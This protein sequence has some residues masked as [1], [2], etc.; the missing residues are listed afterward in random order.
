MTVNHPTVFVRRECYERFGLFD[1]DYKCA[2][3][4]DL[5]LRLFMNGCRFVHIPAVLANMRWGGLSD[6]Q[7][8]LGCRETLL[9]KNKYLPA[10][11]RLNS[12]YY[13]KHIMAIRAPKI[14]QRLGFGFALRVY[15]T[16]FAPFRKRYK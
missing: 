6:S 8:K 12:L 13:Y 11:K 7:W 2:M 9:I 3:D 10:R 4:Y 14:F 16:H 15:R 5:V 1:E